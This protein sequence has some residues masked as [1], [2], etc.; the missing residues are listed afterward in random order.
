MDVVAGQTAATFMDEFK[1]DQT[2]A[3]IWLRYALT[4][5]ITPALRRQ[6]LQHYPNP[7]ELT[8]LLQSS[9]PRIK[10]GDETFNQTAVSALQQRF[11]SS[12]DKR[13]ETAVSWVKQSPARHIISLHLSLIHI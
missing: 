6:L 5:S 8:N 1:G 4:P 3:S 11:C 7:A 9:A 2:P 12:V 10:T 13:L